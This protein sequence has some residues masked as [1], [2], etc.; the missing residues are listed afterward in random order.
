MNIP[1]SPSV[2]FNIP[3]INHGLKQ[4]NGLFKLWKDGL[5]LEFEEKFLGVFDT[6]GVQTVRIAYDDLQDIRY[7]KGWFS[8]KVIFEG[9]S[10]KVFDEV[11][12]TEI[13]TCTLT[14]KKKNRAE[15]RNLISQAQVQLSERKLDQ[16]DE[17]D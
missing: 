7:K 10:M 9:H 14:V 8:D 4:A 11:P 5:E 16:L 12:G 17:G 3:D 1:N 13:A 15:A 2:P 6:S